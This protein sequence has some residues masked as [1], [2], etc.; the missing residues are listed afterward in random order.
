MEGWV[1]EKHLFFFVGSLWIIGPVKSVGRHV[2]KCRGL[3]VAVET[4]LEAFDWLVRLLLRQLEP[5]S[6]TESSNPAVA[7]GN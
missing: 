1:Q 2:T 4:G 5:G 3:L 7:S 6:W